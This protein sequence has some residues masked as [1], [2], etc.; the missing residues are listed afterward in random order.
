M[1][2]DRKFGLR[3]SLSEITSTFWL[4]SVLRH[5]TLA[6]RKA[7]S[8]VKVA[9]CIKLFLFEQ[10]YPLSVSLSNYTAIRR[11][12]VHGFVMVYRLPCNVVTLS[13]VNSNDC[14]RRACLGYLIVLRTT[15]LAKLLY[16][17][18]TWQDFANSGDSNSLEA[19]LQIAD[20]SG[21]YTGYFTTTAQLWIGWSTAI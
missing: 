1:Y 21:Y 17:A 15:A 2:L 11:L 13:R 3:L 5:R 4:K 6:Q 8:K 10:S 14:W 16:A 20:K 12:L 19:F 9:Q 7:K 18:P